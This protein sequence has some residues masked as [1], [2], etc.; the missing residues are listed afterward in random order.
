MLGRTKGTTITAPGTIVLTDSTNIGFP[1]VAF[2]KFT[3]NSRGVGATGKNVTTGA[4]DG[5]TG[6]M[7]GATTGDTHW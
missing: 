4:V 2:T 5:A 6:A 3:P 7:V 1:A